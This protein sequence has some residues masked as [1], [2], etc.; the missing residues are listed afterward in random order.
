MINSKQVSKDFFSDIDK[1]FELMGNQDYREAS[2]KYKEGRKL[3]LEVTVEDGDM[4]HWLHKWLYGKNQTPFGCKLECIH[5]N[6][7]SN[8]NIKIKLIE[9]AETL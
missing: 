1:H 6:N 4:T 5:F 8:E 9:L 3:Y 7:P 2:T